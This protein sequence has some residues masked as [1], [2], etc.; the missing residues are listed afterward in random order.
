MIE[1][2]VE[3]GRMQLVIG[4]LLLDAEAGVVAVEEETRLREGL[5]TLR[6]DNETQ[7][8]DGRAFVQMRTWNKPDLSTVAVLFQG[9]HAPHAFKPVVGVVVAGKNVV[10][11][12]H[13]VVDEMVAVAVH[14]HEAVV[15]MAQNHHAAA[16]A[17][18]P[19]GVEVEFGHAHCVAVKVK[20]QLLALAHFR[21]LVVHVDLSADRFITISDRGS[22][23]RNL[24]GI[25][26]VTGHIV[27]AESRGQATEIRHVFGQHLGIKT[28]QAKQFDLLRARDGVAV[29]DVDRRAVLEALGEAAT[30]RAAQTFGGDGLHRNGVQGRDESAFMPRLDFHFVEHVDGLEDVVVMHGVEHVVD[31]VVLVA[32]AA[33]HEAA[34]LSVNGNFVMPFGVGHHALVDDFPIHVHARQW[35]ALTVFGFFV[36]SAFDEPLGESACGEDE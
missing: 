8:V 36:Y 24:D 23:F 20:K 26:P 35:R 27:E 6:V 3:I 12:H 2:G 34:D 4:E 7:T 21:F 18:V 9:F 33:E 25:H 19:A 30:G 16:L 1:V 32:D 5:I 10:L 22:S 29:A 14:R 31:G 11:R 28:A 13:R 17:H 15:D